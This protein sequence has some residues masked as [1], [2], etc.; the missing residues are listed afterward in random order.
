MTVLKRFAVS[1]GLAVLLLAV[2]GLSLAS[3]SLLAVS[4]SIATTVGSISK[5]SEQ[6][7]KTV[8]KV[9]EGDYKVIAVAQADAEHPGR[10]RVTLADAGNGQAAVFNLYVPQADMRRSDVRVGDVVQAQRRAYGLA[11][12]RKDGGQPFA[13][14]LDA[15]WNGE[16]QPRQ[17]S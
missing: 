5:S 4:D 3:F 7:S 13:L 8:A 1:S 17:V 10:A 14:V 12:A 15:R 2:P 16:L 11:F 6:S 9:A